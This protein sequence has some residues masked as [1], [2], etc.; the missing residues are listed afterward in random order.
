MGQPGDNP[1][2]ATGESLGDAATIAAPATFSPLAKALPFPPDAREVELDA[3]FDDIEF[4]SGSSLASLAAFYRQQM[5]RRGWEEDPSSAKADEESVELTFKHDGVQVVIELDQ[6]SDNTVDVAMECEGLDF[7]GADDPAALVA[8][9]VPQPRSYLFLQKE[10]PRP[11]S[12]QD[13]QYQGDECHFK[14][15]LA[16][17]AAFDFFVRAVRDL[18]WRESRRPIVTDDRRYT[19]FQ[20][21]PVTLSV[22]IFSHEVGSRIILGYENEEKEPVVPPL[23][24]VASA[25]PNVPGTPGAPSGGAAGD[26]TPDTSKVPIDVSKNTGSAT[27]TL[28]E[29]KYVFKHVAA[30]QNKESE[31]TTSLVFSEQPVPLAKMQSMLATKEDFR[32]S[33]LYEFAMPSSLNVDVN[34][35]IGFS[36]SSG[37]TGIGSGIEDPDKQIQIE[38]GRIN[39]TIKMRE[40][41]EFFSRPFRLEVT[42]DAAILTPNTRID[43]AS[44]AQAVTTRQSSLPNSHLLLPEGSN[45]ILSEGSRYLKTTSAEVDLELPAIVDFYRTA[46]AAQN[47]Q[48][49]QAARVGLAAGDASATD[50][51]LAFKGPAETMTIQIRR[52]GEKSHI[53]VASRNEARAR[54]DG[55]LPEPG[56]A[57][58]VM[59]NAHSRNVVITIG[60]QDY[61]L[62]AGQ[63]AEDPKTTLN[64]SVAPGKYDLI[65]KIPGEAPQ[66]ERLDITAGTTW[67]VVTL[68]TG[69]YMASR[70]Y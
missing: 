20:R 67:G 41:D 68:P 11:D 29:E 64:Y 55:M 9:G 27:V 15:K 42:I 62:R 44:A 65:I 38:G 53:E 30:Y 70:L 14:S 69:G 36:F 59:G 49:D 52:E 32:F 23:A 58:L 22:N 40:P 33:D 1:G 19:E 25:A 57:R 60:K 47:W 24:A 48:E 16:L 63:G 7:G 3:T 26:A 17:Q 5:Q 31:G 21:G 12:I 2:I 43:G 45:D 54:Q 37:G 61:P 34:G 66:S 10:I 6:Q 4:T 39:G 28:G 46:L 18:G 51:T 50:A 13:V 8:A 35:Y 56:K